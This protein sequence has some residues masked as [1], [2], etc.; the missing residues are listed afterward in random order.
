[1]SDG[2]GDTPNPDSA[3]VS[4][5]KGSLVIFVG[6]VFFFQCISLRRTKVPRNIVLSIKRRHIRHS[7]AN[8]LSPMAPV[9]RR[10]L[11]APVSTVEKVCILQRKFAYLLS[12][13]F[14]LETK[15]PTEYS[16]CR[17][18]AFISGTAA[19]MPIPVSED[20]RETPHLWSKRFVYLRENSCGK[21]TKKCFKQQT[22]QHHSAL[23][24][25]PLVARSSK[26]FFFSFD[27]AACFLS[28]A[29]PT[30]PCRMTP[31]DSRDTPNSDH[32]RKRQRSKRFVRNR[33][34]PAGTKWFEA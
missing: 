30:P 34:S 2:P 31:N 21:F 5:R 19:T 6:T 28:R 9:I 24:P 14:T 26:V 27:Q 18:F 33:N 23:S 10:T 25:A 13:H 20:S 1:M 11:T 4:S 12:A 8:D 16:F 15:F 29:A 7:N 22:Q 17:A 32:V 3:S